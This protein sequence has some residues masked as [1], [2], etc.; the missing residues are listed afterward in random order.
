MNI[1]C[2]LGLLVGLCFQLCTGCSRRREGSDF[3]ADCHREVLNEIPSEVSD[4]TTHVLFSGNTLTNLTY[5]NM[6]SRFVNLKVLDVSYNYLNENSFSSDVFSYMTELTLVDLQ[7][8]RIKKLP[9]PLLRNSHIRTLKLDYNHI[10][11]LPADFLIDLPKLEEL[12]LS[13]CGLETISGQA[14]RSIAEDPRLQ[15]LDLSYN[16]LETLSLDV[17]PHIFTER[18]LSVRLY[19]NFWNC[20]CKLKWLREAVE[21]SPAHWFFEGYDIVPACEEPKSLK[22]KSWFTARADLYGCPPKLVNPPVDLTASQGVSLT[23]NCTVLTYTEPE[24]AEWLQNDIPINY[25]SYLSEERVY[26]GSH[27]ITSLTVKDFGEQDYGL[28]QCSVNTSFGFVL[29]RTNITPP[30]APDA[31]TSTNPNT[32]MA[33]LIVVIIVV[34]VLVLIIAC[35]LKKQLVHRGKLYMDAH[36]ERSQS[37]KSD[38][39]MSMQDRTGENEHLVVS[40]PDGKPD[41]IKCYSE[42]DLDS[43]PADTEYPADDAGC[44]EYNEYLQAASNQSPV[45][46]ESTNQSS[47]YVEP[48]I[49]DPSYARGISPNESNSAVYPPANAEHLTNYNSGVLHRTNQAAAYSDSPNDSGDSMSDIVVVNR[50]AGTPSG[51]PLTFIKEEPN[52]D[53]AANLL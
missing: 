43:L 40:P 48:G 51:S 23:L 13:N 1:K 20:D 3:I 36:S 2:R 17:A 26:N 28:Y 39:D 46:I 50:L 19:E 21:T 7:R 18:L 35:M 53:S 34:I 31:L 32:L 9:S 14:F 30:V 52:E 25:K 37:H 47:A 49:A 27:Y 42:D 45:Y 29:Q 5:D 8:N 16:S 24:A 22:H 10:K 38:M 12:T 4:S 11:H 33:A 41:V 44:A 15:R 6:L